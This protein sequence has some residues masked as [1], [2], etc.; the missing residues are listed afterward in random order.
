MPTNSS[1]FFDPNESITFI[2]FV[3]NILKF[4]ATNVTDMIPLFFSYCMFNLAGEN[5]KTPIAGFSISCFLFFF[6]FSFDF[7]EVENTISAPYFSKKNFRLFTI[8]T[9]RVALI[10]LIFFAV[11]CGLVFLN[12][13]LLKLFNIED[14]IVRDTTFFL[15]F[16]VPLFGTFFMTTNFLR[17]NCY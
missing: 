4:I 6:A 13:P 17:G 1:L 2:I 10:N 9:F 12:E 8:R 11:S 15:T 3:K 16:Y 7:F 5:E 14:D